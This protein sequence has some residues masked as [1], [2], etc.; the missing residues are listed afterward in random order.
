MPPLYVCAGCRGFIPDAAPECPNCG[1]RLSIAERSTALALVA[2]AGVG[3][4]MV[5]CV[6]MYGPPAAASCTP[7][8]CQEAQPN[9]GCREP[10]GG[11]EFCCG[12]AGSVVNALCPEPD[13]GDDAGPDG[14]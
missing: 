1:S 5:A 13:A 6:V 12:D 14:G 7:D 10:D 2:A 3:L 9:T 4:S 11:S 8:S